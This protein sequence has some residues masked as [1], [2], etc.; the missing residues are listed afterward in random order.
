MSLE[1]GAG[2]QR[3]RG[4]TCLEK[5]EWYWLTV[6]DKFLVACKS[7]LSQTTPVNAVEGKHSLAMAHR[8]AYIPASKPSNYIH[9]LCHC[10]GNG[11]AI[12]GGGDTEGAR[13]FNW[14]NLPDN[15]SLSCCRGTK[16]N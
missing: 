10:R 2:F 16:V 9:M 15:H 1:T 12:G 6:L 7:I 3:G 5:D 4:P 13:A 11:P 14:R 8:D